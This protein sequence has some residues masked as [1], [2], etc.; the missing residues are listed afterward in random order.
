VRGESALQLA[1]VD[2]VVAACC[3]CIFGLGSALYAAGME[4]AETGRRAAAFVSALAAPLARSAI[5]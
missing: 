2:I 3:V 1:T 5:E 4:A